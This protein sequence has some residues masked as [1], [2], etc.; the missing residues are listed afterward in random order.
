MITSEINLKNPSQED[1]NHYFAN[2]IYPVEVERLSYISDADLQI[3]QQE[4]E[5]EL[6]QIKENKK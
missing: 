1:I 6:Q 2:K 3:L 4:A 5:E